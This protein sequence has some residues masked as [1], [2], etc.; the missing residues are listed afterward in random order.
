M[1]EE[2][3]KSKALNILLVEDSQTDI[4]ITLR[5]FEQAEFKNNIQVVNDGQ[6]ALDFVFGQGK[7]SDREKFPKPDLILL[8]IKLPKLDG[9][10]VLEEL[11]KDSQSRLTPV[12]I[13][14]SSKSHEDILRGYSGGAS[15]YIQKPVD[16]DEFVRIVDVFNVYWHT[17]NK[18][19]K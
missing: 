19:P 7:Y 14:T 9:F 12:I 11:K 3:R 4:K 2:T 17:V 1:S 6:E 8:D 10:Q 5:A 18:L 15:G 16:Y 13:L